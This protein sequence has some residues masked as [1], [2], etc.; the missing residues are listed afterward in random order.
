MLLLILQLGTLL[1]CYFFTLE[2]I[3]SFSYLTLKCTSLHCY[4]TVKY[5]KLVT[6]QHESYSLINP[7]IKMADKRKERNKQNTMQTVE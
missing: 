3:T 6:R 2:S 1:L 7:S 4:S 5:T